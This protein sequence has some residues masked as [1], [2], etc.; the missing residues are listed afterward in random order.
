MT[1]PAGTLSQLNSLRMVT[2]ARPSSQATSA[3]SWGAT[4][5]QGG[6]PQQHVILDGNQDSMVTR[7]GQRLF[8]RVR[9]EGRLYLEFTF[10]GM[11]HVRRGLQH[12]EHA[13]LI[14]QILATRA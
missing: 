4:A 12:L 3:A 7:Y 13:E 5:P 8:T 1:V 10:N 14:P 9:M 11:T 6:I 2:L